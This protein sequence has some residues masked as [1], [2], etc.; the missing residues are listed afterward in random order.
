MEGTTL[1]A[2]PA[3]E[4]A[5][6]Q[7]LAACHALIRELLDVRRQDS[8]KLQQM[9][10][11]LQQLL[12]RLYGRSSEKIDPKQMVLFAEMLKALE[13]Q[14]T[15]APAELP[16]PAAATT[17][18]PSKGHGRRRLPADLPRERRIHDLPEAEKPCPCCGTMRQLIGQEVSEQLDYEPAKVRVIEHVRL[19]YLCKACESKAA[20]G[21]PQIA[22]A[23]KPLSP[24]EKG[25]AA[26]GL[27]AYVI[28]SKYSDHLPLHRLERILDRHGIDIARSTMC[29]W[30]AQ[31]A[32]ALRPLYDLMAKEVLASRIIHTDDTPVAVLDRQ[33]PQTRQGRFWVYLGDDSHPYTVFDY[34]PTRK[35]DGPMTFLKDWGKDD[36]RFLQADAFGGYDGIY[37]GEAGGLVVEVACWAHCRRRFHE[38]RKSD[39]RNSAQALAY[40]RLLYDMERETADLPPGERANLRQ[41]RSA[42][43]MVEFRHWMT[44]LRVS[45]GGNV[46]PKSPM[47]EAITY[48]L[49]QWAAL[50]VYLLDGQLRI[51]N[52]AS[53]R[54]LRRIAVGRGNWTFLGSDTGG[55]TAAVL[56]SLI[57]TCE[58]HDVNPFDYLRDV[59]TRI[60]AHPANRL[61]E[62]L[63]GRWKP[64][65]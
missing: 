20:E 65:A 47:G 18:T 15:P 8:R 60:A 44:S 38:A 51:D 21:G 22:T 36:R 48:A 33:L 35:R 57:A 64:I 14:G 12:R 54:A 37:A 39:H 46:L 41:E 40:I 4:P 43:I 42:P 26:P 11:Q 55:A 19:K 58:R 29:D 30:A 49:N 53:E 16:A 7:D 62:L 63:P 9:E 27:L 45:N 31:S 2:P 17:P 59:L 13:A 32:E 3:A 1:Q 61:A 5:L 23:E 10:H 34:T 28:V 50:C 25:L 52:N 6:P 24:I 56:F